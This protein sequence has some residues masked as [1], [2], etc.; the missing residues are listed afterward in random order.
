MRATMLAGRSSRVLV[1]ALMLAAALTVLG[2]GAASAATCGNGVGQPVQPGSS[3]TLGGVAI[4]SCRV[5][6]VGNYVL[7]GN[8]RTLVE[9]WNGTA[10]TRVPSPS[11]ASSY[12]TLNGVAAA[13]ASDAWAVGQS[14]GNPADH[15]FQTLAE[16]WNGTA[17]TQAKTPNPGTGD[18]VLSSVAATSAGNA[19]A[20][21]SYDTGPG[22]EPRAL[23]EH[24][25]GTAWTRV[26]TP[27]PGIGGYL[28]TV[29]ATSASNAWAVGSYSASA[30]SSLTLIDHWNGTA[31]AQVPSPSPGITNYLAGVAALSATDAWAVGSYST[32]GDDQHTLLEHWDG[33][34]WTQMPIASPNRSAALSGIAA[35]SATNIWTT[36]NY[37]Q[38]VR[39]FARL[40]LIYHWDGTAWHRVAS[41]NPNPSSSNWMGGVAV[42]PTAGVWAVGFYLL[43]SQQQT[44]RT[45]AFHCC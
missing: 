10:W 32:G 25:N 43:G 24:W 4:T 30:G 23:A 17:W 15:V 16:H 36:G 8:L 11:P 29:A 26:P 2:P 3:D 27:N 35:T 20:V 12:N 39:P 14:S 42:T 28:I 18:N 38:N 41:P 1:A 44:M 7:A 37:I 9:R 22:T 45:F 40:T 6:A 31:W 21:G 33:T 5:W 34:A 19:W 13:T